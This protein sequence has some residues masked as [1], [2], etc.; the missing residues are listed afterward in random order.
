[1]EKSDFLSE[2]TNPLKQVKSADDIHS[3]LDI[4]IEARKKIISNLEKANSL[5]QSDKRKHKKIIAF[6]T[7]SKLLLNSQSQN[8]DGEFELIKA[9]F[10]K[11]V[12]CMKEEVA[13]T[14][15]HIHNLFEFVSMAFEDGNEMLILVTEL[16]AGTY[17]SRYMSMFG[18]DD[19]QKHSE[20]LMLGER[21][22]KIME[23]I[24]GI[25]LYL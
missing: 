15:K 20:I 12:S 9:E 13:T 8:K 19:Y 23:D 11:N 24:N 10:D 18:S 3:M 6:L 14:D 17:S 1:M 2:L 4:Q 21:K 16:T 5:S 7:E 22:N 25:S